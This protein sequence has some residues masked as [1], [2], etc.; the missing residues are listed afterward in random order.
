MHA[1]LASFEIKYS[2][3]CRISLHFARWNDGKEMKCALIPNDI[4]ALS[5]LADI[6]AAVLFLFTLLYSIFDTRIHKIHAF[7]M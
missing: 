6:V 7:A 4:N 1:L 2:C 5:I 3:K